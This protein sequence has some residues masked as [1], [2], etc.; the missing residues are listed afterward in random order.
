M[1]LALAS[2]DEARAQA[3]W[4][5]IQSLEKKQSEPLLFLNIIN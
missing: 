3:I 1:S 5:S 2:W 4:E